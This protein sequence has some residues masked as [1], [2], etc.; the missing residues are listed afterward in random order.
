MVPVHTVQCPTNLSWTYA[1]LVERC[2]LSSYHHIRLSGPPPSRHAH[3][4]RPPLVSDD[5]SQVRA[6]RRRYSSSAFI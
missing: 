1:C 3:Q 2:A 5:T 4:R 6:D